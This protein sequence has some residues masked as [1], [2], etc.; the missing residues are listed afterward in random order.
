MTTQRKPILS[1][2]LLASRIP[3]K[4][5]LYVV[6]PFAGRVSFSSQQRRAMSLVCDIDQDLLTS[7]D[8]RGLAG[9]DVCIVGGGLAGVT[10]AVVAAALEGNAL[11]VEKTEARGGDQERIDMNQVL[12]T[13]REAGHRDAHPTLNFW[14]HEDV[15]PFTRLPV[16]NWHEGSCEAVAQQIVDGLNEIARRNS[17]GN[18]FNIVNDCMVEGLEPTADGKWK[19]TAAGT[20]AADPALGYPFDIV[21]FAVGFG[22]ERQAT[23]STTPSYWVSKDDT[24]ASVS[25]EA[26]PQ[27]EHVVVSGTGDGGLIEALRL[28]FKDRRAGNLDA[29]TMIALADD[30]LR[31]RVF[32]I[33]NRAFKLYVDH[34]LHRSTG[35]LS[36]ESKNEIAVQLWEDYR[37]LLDRKRVA[38]HIINELGRT[39]TRIPVI[40]LLGQY[41]HPM[42]LTASPYHRLLTAIAIREGWIEYKQID[43]V[44][45]APTGK[46]VRVGKGQSAETVPL[47]DLSLTP[48]PNSLAVGVISTVSLRDAFFVARYGTDSPLF[49]LFKPNKEQVLMIQRQQSLYADQDQLKESYARLIAKNL[50][51]GDPYNVRK[52]YRD[53]QRLVTGYFLSAGLLIALD[54]EE[55]PRFRLT[56]ASA[57]ATSTRA[58]PKRL[59]GC[60]IKNQ[61]KPGR[62]RAHDEAGVE[63]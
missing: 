36:P 4:H 62:A 5:G 6:G 19:I 28:T 23:G 38:D 47:L 15:E 30:R 45:A 35:P 51:Y 1:S 43:T 42:E 14:P 9:K 3:F 31:D 44:V 63:D 39:R 41:A 48:P 24:V 18:K 32:E 55:P 12:A 53:N 33:E 56:A 54:N 16:L 25:A 20:G 27:F 13:I 57:A 21:I 59:F 52:F 37:K 7:G 26:P 10:C 61:K 60:E 50:G 49:D 34:V 11:I 8:E 40:T 2:E 46:T 17:D 22:V 58:I 29:N